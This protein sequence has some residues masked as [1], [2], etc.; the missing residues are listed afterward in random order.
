MP[1]VEVREQAIKAFNGKNAEGDITGGSV[2]AVG[3]QIQWQDGPPGRPPKEP[4]GAF[5]ETV[6]Y[7]ALQRLQ[8]YQSVPKFACRENAL[9]ITHLEES[10]HWLLA[11]RAEREAREVMGTMQP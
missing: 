11:R 10:I 8:A 9:A 6:L 5:V 3:L 7:A 1:K 4:N 2:F